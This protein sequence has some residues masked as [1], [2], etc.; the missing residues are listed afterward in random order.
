MRLTDDE[1]LARARANAADGAYEPVSPVLASDGP[2]PVAPGTPRCAFCADRLPVEVYPRREL[3]TARPLYYCPRCYGFW[4]LA[5]VLEHG[6]RDPYDDHPAF[7]TA[8]AP[9]R[10]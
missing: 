10:C 5:G 7:T 4:A 9:P 1:W 6:V 8:P 3:V 2:A